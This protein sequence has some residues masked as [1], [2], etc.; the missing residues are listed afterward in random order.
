MDLLLSSPL[1][2]SG[3]GV[4]LTHTLSLTSNHG[5]KLNPFLYKSLSTFYSGKLVLNQL[6]MRKRA[7]TDEFLKIGA[8]FDFAPAEGLASPTSD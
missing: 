4:S 2:D 8:L 1:P 7:K 3:E 6:S 5:A